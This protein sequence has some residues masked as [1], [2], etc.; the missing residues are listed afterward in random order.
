MKIEKLRK[1]NSKKYFLC[2]LILVVVLTITITFI[3]SKANFRMT[4][5]IPLTEGKVVSSPYD[6]NIVALYLD[7]T[8]QDKDTL[9]PNGYRINEEESY[10]YKG[11]R[12]N[13][14]NNA[15]LYTDELGN[16]VFSGISKSSKC[17]LY[18]DKAEASKPATM[19]ELL[20]NYYIYKK[21]RTS[22]NKDFNVPFVEETKNTVYV[23]PDGDNFSYYFA[24]NPLDNWVEFGGYYWRII[25]INGDGTIRMIYQGTAANEKG[26]GTQ[27]NGAN[28]TFN[29]SYNNNAYVGYW[30]QTGVLRGLQS[31]SNAYTELNN[32][33]A[34]S[35][36]KQGSTYFNLIDPDAGFCGDRQPSSSQTTINGSGGTG[37]I[38]TIYAA[39]VRLIPDGKYPTTLDTPTVI[40]TLN[41]A[42]NDDL[43]TYTGA[44][45]GQGNHKLANPVGMITVDEVSYAGL[46][47]VTGSSGNYLDTDSHYWTM[48]PFWYNPSRTYP[49]GVFFL[50]SG[51]YLYS[52]NVHGTYG[53][54]PVI[55][56]RA[57][58]TLS[59]D[60]TTSNPFKVVILTTDSF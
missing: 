9:I 57:D 46:V 40:P 42:S 45:A 56:L 13:I 35:N 47:F 33:F 20:D 8:E 28:Y 10:C 51:G 41:C 32:W 58:V 21:V 31:P 52:D 16:H 6:I 4:A 1:K 27:I 34:S 60:G 55:N 24:G 44:K 7:G 53:V 39:Y 19:Q 43:Y 25:R 17:I 26:T 48:S 30:Y 50:A 15:K 3:G 18:L 11:S 22:K 54:R 36:I 37:T 2:G 29:N 59:G 38:H 12:S 14:D 23:A 5:S 49:A